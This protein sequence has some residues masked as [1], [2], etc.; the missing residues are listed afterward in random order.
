MV[1]VINEHAKVM[2]KEINLI[3]AEQ[4]RPRRAQGRDDHPGGQLLLAS[5]PARAPTARRSSSATWRSSQAAYY[6]RGFINVKV[7]KPTVALS[8]DK[9]FIYI[10]IKIDEGEPVPDRQDR[11]LRRPASSRRS[12]LLAVLDVAHGAT[13]STESQGPKD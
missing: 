11:L 9:R 12:E 7:E 1:F 8:P 5:S 2:V 3:G 4:G 13:S 10:T 6:D